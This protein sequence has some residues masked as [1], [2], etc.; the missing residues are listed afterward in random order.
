ME[1]DTVAQLKTKKQLKAREGT[2]QGV[3]PEYC[4]TK[5]TVKWTCDKG[6]TRRRR[7]GHLGISP[8]KHTTQ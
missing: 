3:S 4:P 8:D 5:T 1:P 2:V 6:G 7:R